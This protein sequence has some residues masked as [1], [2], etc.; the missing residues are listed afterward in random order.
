MANLQCTF[1]R[2]DTN[3]WKPWDYV[4]QVEKLKSKLTFDFCVHC[5]LTENSLVILRKHAR[6]SLFPAHCFSKSAPQ[7]GPLGMLSLFRKRKLQNFEK[8]TLSLKSLFERLD[9]LLN[10]NQ[11]NVF[12]IV[13]DQSSSLYH[14]KH[15]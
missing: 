7:Y 9:I 12:Q 3:Q 14:V 13:V 15:K 11:K 8:E 10:L 6:I 4:K 5:K 2:A 1:G